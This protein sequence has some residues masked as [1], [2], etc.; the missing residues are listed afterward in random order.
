MVEWF[1]RDEAGEWFYTLLSTPERVLGVPD[2][3]LALPLRELC[4]DTDVAPLR[5]QPGPDSENIM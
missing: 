1:R 3:N 2:L 4:E 5:V